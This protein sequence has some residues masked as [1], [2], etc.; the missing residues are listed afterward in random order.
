MA[1][2]DL[3]LY[4]KAKKINSKMISLKKCDRNLDDLYPYKI[5]PGRSH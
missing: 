2:I 4:E 5:S 3:E 1:L